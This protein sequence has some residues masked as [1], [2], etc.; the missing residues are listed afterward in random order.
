M[1]NVIVTGG[2]G[3]TGNALIHRLL[4]RNIKV[5]AL[6]R[7]DSFRKK[8]LPSNEPLLDIVDCSMEDYPDVFFRLNHK[9]YD[10]FFHL[11]WDGST[12][13]KKVDNRNNYTLQLR[14]VSF[15]I[16][17]VE[18]CHKLKCPVFLMTGT[19]AQYGRKDRPLKETDERRPE[20][21]YGMA[22]QCAEGMTR[23]LC[24]EYDI[25][26]IWSILFSVYGPNDATESLIDKT[27]RGIL[28][29]ETM[30]YTRGVQMWDY[31]YSY[32]AADALI[33]LAEKGIDGEA[34]NVS[35]GIQRPLYEY[36]NEMYDELAPGICPRLGEIEYSDR[37]V[38]F[39]G[40]D[41]SKLKA[42]TGFSPA[43]S[44]RE[45]IRAIAE[46]VKKEETL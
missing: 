21:G 33:M 5:T 38:M 19:Q 42:A 17:A 14:N 28:R 6:V 18:L 16:D 8:Y 12:G 34:Y 43:Y 2:T 23:L 7:P 35:G 30:L 39:L 44:F 37:S 40:A 41:I 29:G 24:S 9:Q 45:G 10:V 22:K 31:L 11:A 3:V 15:A 26:H 20:N 32:D 36:I 25:K 13:K 1:K 27:I 46:E 4:H